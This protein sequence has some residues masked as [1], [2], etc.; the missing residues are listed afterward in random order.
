MG[1]TYDAACGAYIL[2][3]HYHHHVTVMAIMITP[4]VLYMVATRPPA[5]GALHPCLYQ[6]DELLLGVRAELGVNV[7]HVRAH[8]VL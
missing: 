8:G 1:S 3:N 7:L 6:V 5:G 2:G 4:P